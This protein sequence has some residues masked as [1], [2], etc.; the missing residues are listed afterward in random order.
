MKRA[1]VIVIV[2]I[3]S[4]C[5]SACQKQSK[6]VEIPNPTNGLN[7]SGGGLI[8]F[9]NEEKG[10]YNFELFIMNADG[11]AVTQLTENPG[12][13]GGPSF[14][15]DMKKIAY[16]GTI[17][18]KVQIVI[19]DL[20]SYLMGKTVEPLI[21]TNEGNNYYPDWSPDGKTIAFNSDRDGAFKIYT[22]NSDGTDQKVF[23]DHL[24]AAFPSWSPDGKKIA[25]NATY[26]GTKEICIMNVDGSDFKRLTDNT[27]DDQFP[28]W[29]PDG[30]RIAYSSSTNAT[31]FDISIMDQNGENSMTLIKDVGLDEL[32]KWS[33]DGKQI[34]FRSAITGSDQ[35]T[36][37][38]MD[39]T[40]VHALTT[41]KGKNMPYDWCQTR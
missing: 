36:L 10:D 21:L 40:N 16:S 35:L 23:I 26:D 5:L 6:S 7:G 9:E 27:N 12:Y 20:E 2:L 22:M 38:N 32:P 31:N 41:L 1:F 15:T 30:Q 4:L 25:F 37:M 18:G 13:D 33:P 14:S 17:N 24:E 8:A 39:G 34:L 19:F 28:T 11:T 3:V 29:S